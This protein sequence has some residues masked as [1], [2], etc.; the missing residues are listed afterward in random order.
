MAPQTPE[1]PSYDPSQASVAVGSV[2]PSNVNGDAIRAALRGVPFTTCYRNALRARGRRA[3]GSATLN[4]SID[5]TG[6]ITGAILTGADW[7]PEMTRCMQ[8]GAMGVQLRPGSVDQSG[9]TAEV[10]LSFRAP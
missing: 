7:L 8:G 3:F 2:T 6:K 5:P 4:L 1:A 9:G 10:W